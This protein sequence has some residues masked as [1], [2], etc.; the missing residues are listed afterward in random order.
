VIVAVNLDPHTPQE[1]VAVIPAHLGAAPAF[2]VTD[3]LT[4][5]HYDWRIGR[6]YVR[7]VPGERQAHVLRV[8]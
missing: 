2:T 3:L 8:E 1:G 5:D 6:N 4:G 7:L